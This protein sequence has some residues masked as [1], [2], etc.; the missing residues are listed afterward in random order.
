MKVYITL[1][2]VVL[3]LCLACSSP[4]EPIVMDGITIISVTVTHNPSGT[5]HINTV[6]D[7]TGDGYWSINLLCNNQNGINTSGSINGTSYRKIWDVDIPTAYG[8][9][10]NDY[11]IDI[12]HCNAHDSYEGVLP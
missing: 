10:G 11:V 4:T 7:F 6:I 8:D 9:C 12:H 5:H 2:G 3:V 1:V